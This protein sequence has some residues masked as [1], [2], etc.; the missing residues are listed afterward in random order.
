MKKKMRERERERESLIKVN[1]FQMNRSRFERD[2]YND[3]Q[4]I[5]RL[6]SWKEEKN[7]KIKWEKITS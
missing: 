5:A 2:E 1:L 4:I 7:K 6:K 3:C